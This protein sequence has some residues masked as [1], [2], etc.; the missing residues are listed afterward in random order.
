MRLLDWFR[1]RR[2]RRLQRFAKPAYVA[3]V[4]R[5]NKL[6]RRLETLLEA[7]QAKLRVAETE[8]E[9]LY[10]CMARNQKRVEAETA[11][12]NRAIAELTQEMKP[13]VR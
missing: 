6:R 9:E 2:L 10:K 11:S 7:E 1:Y 8:K 3:E 13:A 5:L 4:N 12:A